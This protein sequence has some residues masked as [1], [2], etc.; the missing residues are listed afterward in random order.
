MIELACAA[1]GGAALTV[2]PGLEG[3][4]GA[5][6]GWLLIA[7][8]ALDLRCFWL[9]DALVA[10]LALLAIGGA[11]LGIAPAPLDRMIGAAAGF[12]ALTVIA[13]AYRMTRGREGMGQG[14]PKLLGAIGLW[15]GWQPLPFVL[16][17][18]SLL[19]LAAVA[20]MMLLGRPLSAKT[21]L[22]LGAMLAAAAFPAWLLTH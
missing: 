17:G 10:P 1:A 7:L 8:A 11:A 2:A 16:L 3:V 22:P 20:V 6:F 19:G 9:P 13:L 18:G 21:A 15:L 5:L 14:D 12:G 4:A